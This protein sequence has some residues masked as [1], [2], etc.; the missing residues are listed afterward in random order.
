MQ[1]IRRPQTWAI[2][3]VHDELSNSCSYKM[4]TVLDE[5]TREALCVAVRPKMNAHDVL[6]AMNPLLMKHGKPEFIRSDNGLEFI[7]G[8]LQ[9]WLKKVGIQ[10]MQI[11]SGSRWKNGYNER[12]NRTLR[13][14]FLNAEWFHSTRQAQAT[15]NVWLK[16]YKRI[17]P[18]HALNMRPPLTGT[19]LEKVETSGHEKWG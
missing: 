6:D 19:L 1:L 8:H 14:K 3:F 4:L 2:D 10:P 13:R 16:R 5:Y 17:R 7:V 15:F 18:H 11:Y 9:E 12:F